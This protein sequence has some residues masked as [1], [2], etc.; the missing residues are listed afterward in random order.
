MGIGDF[1]P[2]AWSW[3]LISKE[4]RGQGYLDTS[5]PTNIFMA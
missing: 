3:T 5:T 1:F 4:C 2:G